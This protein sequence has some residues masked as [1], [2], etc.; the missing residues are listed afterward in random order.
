KGVR[1]V[2]VKTRGYSRGIFE[3]KTSL[4]EN[5]RGIIEITSSNIWKEFYADMV[6]PDG[7]QA[8]FF[9]YKG[10]GS[11]TLGSFTLE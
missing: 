3:I 9:I 8:L 6:I 7:V 10:T 4:D 5:P 1:R 2:K 11:A